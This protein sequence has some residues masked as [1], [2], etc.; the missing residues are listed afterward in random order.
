[1]KAE[2]LTNPSGVSRSAVVGSRAVS[3]VSAVA[4][5]GALS[6]PSR[7]PENVPGRTGDTGYWQPALE[8]Q[9]TQQCR[10]KESKQ[11]RPPGYVISELLMKEGKRR[12]FRS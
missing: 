11:S 8:L 3:A 7:A 2:K 12:G 10:L 5:F 4:G 6:P 1:M 9:R